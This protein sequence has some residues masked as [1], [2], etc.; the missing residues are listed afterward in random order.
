LLIPVEIWYKNNSILVV[1]LP[2]RIDVRDKR[3]YIY[4][5]HYLGHK[6]MRMHKIAMLGTGLI[7]RFYTMRAMRE[8]SAARNE[9]K[10]FVQA[11]KGMPKNLQREFGIPRWTADMAKPFVSPESG[12][13]LL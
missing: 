9:I 13:L 4:D 8:T 10:L 2:A 5:F 6:E 12:I 11:N 7:G 3:Y 1:L